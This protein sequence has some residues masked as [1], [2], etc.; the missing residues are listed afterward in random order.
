MRTVSQ[1]ALLAAGPGIVIS[2]MAAAIASELLQHVRY[3]F[4]VGL[5][6]TGVP[7]AIAMVFVIAWSVGRRALRLPVGIC[8]RQE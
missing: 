4:D 6:S 1:D 8:L 5:W 2:L 7:A 3:R